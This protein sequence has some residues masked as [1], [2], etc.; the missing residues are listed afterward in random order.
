MALVSD[1]TIISPQNAALKVTMLSL[2]KDGRRLLSVR[3]PISGA[4]AS[5]QPS[6]AANASHLPRTAA[7]R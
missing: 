6:V 7:V 1:R 2:S 5:S 3:K 4:A